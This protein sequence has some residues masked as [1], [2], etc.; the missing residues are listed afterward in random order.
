MRLK[1]LVSKLVPVY[2]SE[3]QASQVALWLLEK[4]LKISVSQILI[5]PEL[6]LTLDQS[7][8]LDQW[9]DQIIT[10]HK[11]YQYILGS[12]PF[13][14]LDILVEPPI[15][16]PRLETEYWV[17]LII[18]RFAKFKNEPINILDLC[19]GS[20]CI[21]LSLA[22]FFNRSQVIAI[23]I[24]K[25]ACDLISKNLIHNQISNVTVLQSDLYQNLDKQKFDLIIANPPYIPQADYVKLDFSVKLW[26]DPQA[27]V[28]PDSDLAI[29][30]Q[31]IKLAPN[32]LQSKHD[33]ILSLWLEI[34]STQD[35]SVKTLMQDKFK[36]TELVLDQFGRPRVVIGKS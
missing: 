7:K 2:G 29:I 21:A 1:E 10:K 11:P 17:S 20:G 23:D 3:Q 34:D 30:T 26:E 25:Q 9:L 31:I 14:D 5:L 4:L 18:E 36:Q 33:Q 8:S 16:I 19:S 28:S 6:K 15:L 35:D 22:K 24:S 32:Y 27:L 13:L 12:V